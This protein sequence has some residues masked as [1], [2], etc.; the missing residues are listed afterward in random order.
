MEDVVGS[1]LALVSY[2]HCDRDD[3]DPV[4]F[5]HNSIVPSA[6]SIVPREYRIKG[7][8]AA[9]S[10]GRLMRQTKVLKQ[11]K[12]PKLPQ[13]L[14]AQVSLHNMRYAVRP[15]DEMV[16]SGP[17]RQV[18]GRGKYRLWTMGAVLRACWGTSRTSG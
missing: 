14:H 17:R 13:L 3:A 6:N 2:T 18:K 16:L 1:V 10:H 7:S 9:K 11:T 4:Q 8:F 15:S 5:V 12:S